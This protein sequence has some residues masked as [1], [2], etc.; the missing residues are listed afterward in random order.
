[1][2]NF[3]FYTPD[4]FY[5]WQE[6]SDTIW[7]HGKLGEYQN[8]YGTRFPYIL[9][10]VSASEPLKAK[11]WDSI[12]LHTEAKKYSPSMEEYT[13][14]R[15]KTFNKAIFYNSRQC[16]GEIGLLVKDT[17]PDPE[18]YMLQQIVDRGDGTMIIDRNE[19]DWGINDIRDIRIDY[20][21]PIFDSSSSSVQSEYYIDKVLNTSTLDI[22]KSWEQLESFR[23]NYLV[24]RLIFDNFDDVK[25]IM[26]YSVEKETESLR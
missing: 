9:E 8:F 14:E 20:T 3:Y 22:N 11:I 16:S 12:T 26:N 23:D 25:L 13:E 15:F 6:N 7:E 17:Q 4:K 18:N 19:G 2:P 10:Y 5:S 24:I 21:Q 1:M